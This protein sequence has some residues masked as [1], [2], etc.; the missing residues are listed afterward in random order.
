[1]HF[2]IGVNY[3]LFWVIVHPGSAHV[4]PATPGK[5]GPGGVVFIPQVFHQARPSVACNTSLLAYQFIYGTYA[6]FF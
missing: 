3:P 6:S 1:M 2:A 5:F 4:V